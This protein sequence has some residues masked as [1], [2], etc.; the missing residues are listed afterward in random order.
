MIIII[1]SDTHN[2]HK[3]LGKLPEGDV[4]IHC[5]DMT[6]MGREHEIRDFMKWYSNL[7][8]FKYKICCAG[9]HDWLFER[10][11][12][13]A[14]SLVSK[15][16]IYLQDQEVVIE[17]I[18]FYG[19]PVN[20]PFFDWAFNRPEEKLVQHWQAIP[21]DTDVLIT[22]Q[23]P[24]GIMDWSVYDKKATGSP[25]LYKEVLERI[26]PSL[27]VFGH[28]HS[29]HG[30]KVIEDTTFINASNLD[31]DYMC[32]YDPILVELVDGNVTILNQ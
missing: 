31:E 16:V 26:K 7:E 8:Q 3:H 13:H 24:F 12:I 25:S 19:T 17:G 11:G 27:H 14:R 5:G 22:H 1:I 9:N 28:I 6:S 32:V 30:V 4:I 21:D 2:K 20:L 23:P 18:K 15:N 10:A 29:G